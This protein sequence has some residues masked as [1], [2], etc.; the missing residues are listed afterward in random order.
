MKEMRSRICQS[1]KN[2]QIFPL[3]VHPED[4]IELISFFKGVNESIDEHRDVTVVQPGG[5]SPADQA[6]RVI[7][8]PHTLILNADRANESLL[9]ALGNEMNNAP[10][11]R[12][13]QF[14]F[15]KDTAAMQRW[16]S[17]VLAEIRQKK[18]EIWPSLAQRK[19]DI[20]GIID[21]VCASLRSRATGQVAMMT[22]EARAYLQ[23]NPGERVA[24][25]VTRIRAAFLQA[26]RNERHRYIIDVE[27]LKAQ[28]R[29]DLYPK[30]RKRESAPPPAP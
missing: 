4:H 16:P 9:E 29:T 28:G 8:M 15:E 27:Q 3:V 24:N 25:I 17:S 19:A 12:L 10:R 5:E 2:G 18:L 22:D 6:K 7:S 23:K 20:G 11:V 1:A 14:R 30:L 26:C 21:A 13:V